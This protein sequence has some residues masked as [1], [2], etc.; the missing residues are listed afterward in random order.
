MRVVVNAFIIIN[1]QPF[2]SSIPFCYFLILLIKHG[3]H[4]RGHRLFVYLF[5]CIENILSTYFGRF[6]HLFN[7][8]FHVFFNFFLRK[9]TTSNTFTF[10]WHFRDLLQ[11]LF[12]PN[13]FRSRTELSLDLLVG[14]TLFII[15][16]FIICLLFLIILAI[17]QHLL[18][19]Y[20]IDSTNFVADDLIEHLHFS[21]AARMRHQEQC[22]KTL[23]LEFQVR[24]GWLRGVAHSFGCLPRSFTAIRAKRFL[25]IIV[26]LSV[27]MHRRRRLHLPAYWRVRRLHAL[28]NWIIKEVGTPA[29][30]R[31]G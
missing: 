12:N 16:V 17:I 11:F 4:E 28:I 25:M 19:L 21:A 29:G 1:R 24:L 13:C 26:W 6:R 8:A 31:I 3:L 10:V 14:Y 20:S 27:W 15:V 2:A 9:H 23:L 18:I 22:S 5:K 30:F 7:D